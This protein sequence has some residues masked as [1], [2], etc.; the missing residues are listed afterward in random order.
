VAKPNPNRRTELPDATPGLDD[1]ELFRRT[2][3][4]VK[5]V[6]GGRPAAPKRKRPSPAPRSR[7]ADERAALRESLLPPPP[8]ADVETGEG[9]EYKRPGVQDAV[10]RKLRRGH[11]RIDAELDLHGLTRDKAHAELV[12]FLA[13][14]R[15]HQARCVRIIHGKGHN[16]GP[17]GP[18]IKQSLR[19]W[20]RR[21]EVLAFA[22]A[23]QA[24]GGSG[25]T[26]VLLRAE[27]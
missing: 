23:P 27:R 20:L 11:Y 26:L 1:A 12:T 5:P 22:T 7:I 14:S 8:D 2:V 19:S 16:S 6:T 25:A 17:R 4:K 21:S 3:G 10:L 13:E 18:I 24:Q 15:G 9:H